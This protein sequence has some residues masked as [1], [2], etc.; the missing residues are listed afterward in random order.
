MP[1]QLGPLTDAIRLLWRNDSRW[2]DGN[3]RFEYMIE[4]H[5]ETR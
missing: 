1:M 2:E 5:T 4:L 3:S